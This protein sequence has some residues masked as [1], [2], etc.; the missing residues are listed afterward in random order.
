MGRDAISFVFFFLVSCSAS[1]FPFKEHDT[2]LRFGKKEKKATKNVLPLTHRSVKRHYTKETNKKG[3]E[4]C[5]SVGMTSKLF[6]VA[7]LLSFVFLLRA[8][9]SSDRFSVWR[10]LR[11]HS[12][13][14]SLSAFPQFLH[15]EREQLVSSL[16]CSFAFFQLDVCTRETKVCVVWFTF[17]TIF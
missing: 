16:V 2:I 15:S 10:Q 11:P 14:S 9:Y 12:L 17:L 6:L 5:W 1:C 8:R 3:E 7:E 4:R 13:R